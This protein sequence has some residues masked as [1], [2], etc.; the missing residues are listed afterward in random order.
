MSNSETLKSEIPKRV[1]VGIR[2][3]FSADGA[4]TPASIIWGDGRVFDI[5][6]VT[7]VRRAAS[8]AGSMGIRYTVSIMGQVRRLFFENAYSDTGRARWF[9]ESGA[10]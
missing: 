4:M 1:Y 7:E 9:V 6:R 2:V 3:N 5:D 8:S 10:R